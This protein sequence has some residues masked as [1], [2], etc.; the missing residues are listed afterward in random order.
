[1]LYCNAAAAAAAAAAAQMSSPEKQARSR[2]D[3]GSCQ[4]TQITVD[5]ADVYIYTD[6]CRGRQ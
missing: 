4:A 5:L 6:T 3:A 1:M 2:R